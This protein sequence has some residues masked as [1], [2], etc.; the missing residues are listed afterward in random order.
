MAY[1]V[2]TLA[3]LSGVSVRT[4]HFYDEIGLL[5][6]AYQGENNYR[7]YDEEQLLLLQQILFYKEMGMPLNEIKNVLYNEAFDKIEALLSHK[8][9]LAQRIEHSEKMIKT[10]DQTISYLRGEG[11]MK[12]QE[13]Y[14]GFDSDI[15]KEHE[16]YL[17]DSGIATQS[18]L[19]ECNEKIKNW[20]DVEKNEF[21]QDIEAIM[22]ALIKAMNEGLTPESDQVQHQMQRHYSWLQLTWSPTKEKYL[23]LMQLYQTPEFRIFYDERDPKLLEFMLKAMAVFAHRELSQGTS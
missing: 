6:P 18:F 12:D 23:G 3:K 8:K 7:Y 14:Y 21:I 20:N 5:K 9:I 19:D 4:L 15:Q 1:T 11:K 10:I 16:K 17:V 22:Q 2:N 13:F